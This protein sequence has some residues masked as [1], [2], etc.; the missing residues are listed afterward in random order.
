MNIVEPWKVP[1]GGQLDFQ[2]SYRF[3]IGKLDATLAG[4]IHNLLNQYYIEK[5]YNPQTA[6]DK[7]DVKVEES[8]VRMFFSQGRTFNLRLKIQF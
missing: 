8:Q 1:T 5:A 2:A 4:N 3:Q 6:S 7:A